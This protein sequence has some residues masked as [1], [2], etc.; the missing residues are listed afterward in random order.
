MLRTTNEIARD[1]LRYAGPHRGKKRLL[2][3]V[4]KNPSS[5]YHP[6]YVGSENQNVGEKAAER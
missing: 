3:V 5:L 4:K 1:V 6:F 2:V